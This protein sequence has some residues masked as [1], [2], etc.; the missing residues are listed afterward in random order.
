MPGLVLTLYL[1]EITLH[2]AWS[3]QHG[4]STV[5]AMRGDSVNLTCSCE[6]NNLTQFHSEWNY[7][8]RHGKL[9][10]PKSMENLSRMVTLK[11]PN[12]GISILEITDVDLSD[13]GIYACTIHVISPPPAL[14][15]KGN[16]T[17]LVVHAT[18]RVWLSSSSAGEDPLVEQVMCVVSEFYPSSINLSMISTCG[19]SQYFENNTHLMKNHDGTFNMTGRA[20]VTTTGCVNGTEVICFAK[21]V[22][23]EW[24]RTIRISDVKHEALSFQNGVSTVTAMRGDSVNLTCSCGRNNLTRFRAEWNFLGRHGELPNPKSMENISR[25]ATIKEPNEGISI[26]EITDVDLSDAGI[27]ACAIHVILPPPALSFKG[28]GTKLVVHA[29]PRVWLSSSSSDEKHHPVQVMCVA[30]KFYP[31][32]LNLT[33]STTCGE[34]QF[35]ENNTKLIKN[36]DGTYNTTGRALVNTTGCVNGT[37]VICSAKHAT[38][39]WS[40]TIRMSDA[41]YEGQMQQLPSEVLIRAGAFVAFVIIACGIILRYQISCENTKENVDSSAA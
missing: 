40:R 18:P 28:N 13:A 21:H 9:S 8:G 33:M 7:L 34:S 1:L 14:S 36:P 17:K 2:R 31:S 12:K 6:C 5:T 16:E 23:G 3:T 27:Y 22:T 35:F 24:N 4:I 30:S 32:S 26:L 19:E 38:G 37:E 15:F 29:P 20:L 10:N 39:E 25:M 11:D 41:M